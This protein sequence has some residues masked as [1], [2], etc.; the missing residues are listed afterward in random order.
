MIYVCVS[1]SVALNA[2]TW[3]L[4]WFVLLFRINCC[5]HKNWLQNNINS[6]C[7]RNNKWKTKPRYIETALSYF[8]MKYCR[9]AQFPC[10]SLF[11]S[12]IRCVRER[13]REIF[14]VFCAPYCKH[15]K[16]PA[17]NF[18]QFCIWSALK[19]DWNDEY[20]QERNYFVA[21]FIFVICVVAVMVS[22]SQIA[23]TF[24]NFFDKFENMI[25]CMLSYLFLPSAV[26]KCLSMCV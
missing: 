14:C 15:F 26:I 7:T 22:N 25:S 12:L 23:D 18:K 3:M 19:D 21:V 4:S 10:F 13:E 9:S 6:V 17:I 5:R 16:F 1:E 11:L 8:N 24:G 2:P 20:S